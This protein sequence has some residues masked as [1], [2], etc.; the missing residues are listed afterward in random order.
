MKIFSYKLAVLELKLELVVAG[1]IGSEWLAVTYFERHFTVATKAHA[2]IDWRR[3]LV[4]QRH[5]VSTA[6]CMKTVVP[7]RRMVQQT[8]SMGQKQTFAVH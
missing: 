8:S 7:P 2:E 5:P 3:R 6:P 4:Q 1:H